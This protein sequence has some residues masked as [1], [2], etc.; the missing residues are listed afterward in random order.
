MKRG[1]TLIELLVVV[2]IIGILSAVALP[3]Y[4]TAVEKSRASEVYTVV[5]AMRRNYEICNYTGDCTQEM[6]FGEAG[7]KP[8]TST[9][10]D[11]DYNTL[12]GTYYQFAATP[13]G[14]AVFFDK[15]LSS[16][17]SAEFYFGWFPRTNSNPTDQLVCWGQTDKGKKFCKSLCGFAQCDVERR[18]EYN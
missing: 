8:K 16:V 1:F 7:M 10:N 11:S 18:T 14:V 5:A 2:L 3:Q 9:G 13:W 17:N 6:Y 15:K 4:T 12:V